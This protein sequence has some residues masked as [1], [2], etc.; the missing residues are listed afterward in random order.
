MPV[1]SA[2]PLGARGLRLRRCLSRRRDR[3]IPLG[4][5]DLLLH[6]LR[7]SSG[8]PGSLPSLCLRPPRSRACGSRGPSITW[9]ESAA[10][11]HGRPSRGRSFRGTAWRSATCYSPCG[12]LA[13]TSFT[14]GCGTANR[15]RPG[16]GDRSPIPGSRSARHATN[17]G[18]WDLKTLPTRLGASKNT[19]KTIPL[20]W[21]FKRRP[22]SAYPTVSE[23]QTPRH[24][25]GSPPD[26]SYLSLPSLS[27]GY[28][29][30]Q[31][32]SYTNN[33]CGL[34][35]FLDSVRRH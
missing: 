22:R 34:S 9:C 14:P 26:G 33:D 1:R 15:I 2:T 32:T 31:D 28:A 19:M 25:G 5:R 11:P 17:P 27:I 10:G 23:G 7:R 29:P 6:A 30:E 20:R 8:D 4:P 18:P 3:E 35:T 16:A 24:S 13:G 21:R 12:A